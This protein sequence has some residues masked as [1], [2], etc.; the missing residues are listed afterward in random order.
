LGQF[1]IYGRTQAAHYEAEQYAV[2]TAL[3]TA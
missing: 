1:L 3:N 2:S